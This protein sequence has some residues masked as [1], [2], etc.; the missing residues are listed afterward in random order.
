MTNALEPI[1][2]LV[3]GAFACDAADYCAAGSA[4]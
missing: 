2:D 3:G 4:R 1:H